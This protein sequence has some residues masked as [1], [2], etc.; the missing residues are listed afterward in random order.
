MNS[1]EVISNAGNK[2]VMTRCFVRLGLPVPKAA[3]CYSPDSAL[4]AAESIGYPLVVKPIVGSWGRMIARLDNEETARAIFEYKAALPS[5][6]QKVFFLQEYIEKPGRDIRCIV[7]GSDA[8]AT[9]FRY[10]DHWITNIKRGGVGVADSG[11]KEIAELSRLAANAVGGGVVSVDLIERS[12]GDLLVNE[13][14]H[15]MEFQEAASVT[16]VDIAGHYVDYC[17]EAA[18]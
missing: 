13:V 11:S 17:L 16:E 2:A 6:H 15:T 1:A 8:I 10:S 14:N 3:V 4:E 12:N 5:L 18:A 9:Y 7:I